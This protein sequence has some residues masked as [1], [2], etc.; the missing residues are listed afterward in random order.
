MY[1]SI[2]FSFLMFV[3]LILAKLLSLKLSKMPT[4]IQLLVHPVALPTTSSN[5]T[6]ESYSDNNNMALVRVG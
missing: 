2:W 6:L 3:T 1:Y 4:N 5:Y